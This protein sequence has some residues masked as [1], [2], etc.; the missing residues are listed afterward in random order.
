MKVLIITIES[1]DDEKE[2]EKLQ[3]EF[4]K[5]GATRMFLYVLSDNHKNLDND[6][7]IQF[8]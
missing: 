8:L 5:L 1:N 2:Q 7:L 3:N 6:L 4:D